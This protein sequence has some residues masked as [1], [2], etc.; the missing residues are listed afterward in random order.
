[1][2]SLVLS[3]ND[4]FALL[5]LPTIRLGDLKIIDNR[6]PLNVPD[7]FE[8]NHPVD[9]RSFRQR[10]AGDVIAADASRLG[11]ASKTTVRLTVDGLLLN[12]DLMNLLTTLRGDDTVYLPWPGTKTSGSEAPDYI[13]HARNFGG[14]Y[15]GRKFVEYYPRIGEDVASGKLAYDEIARLADPD[16]AE[17]LIF[18]RKLLHVSRDNPGR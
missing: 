7:W 3:L 5:P 8:D 6:Y 11:A 16:G 2:L 10:E 18:R 4:S 13:L 14:L 15:P 12:H 17:L 9:R 1:V